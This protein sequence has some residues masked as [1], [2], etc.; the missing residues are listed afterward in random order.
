MLRKAGLRVAVV[1][2]VVCCACAADGRQGGVAPARYAIVDSVILA[3]KGVRLEGDEQTLAD[4]RAFAEGHGLKLFDTA[5]VSGV[6]FVLEGKVDVT[7]AFVRAVQSRR[8][9]GRLELPALDVPLTT[10]AFVT[11]DDFADPNS[12]IKPLVEALRTLE[13]EF[14]PRREEID[15]LLR[16]AE[17]APAERR[18]QLRRDAEL[19][20]QAG[21]AA[22]DKRLKELTDPVYRDIARALQKFGHAEGVSLFFDLSRFRPSDKLPP[23]GLSLP[24]AA[25]NVTRKFVAEYNG[26]RLKP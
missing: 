21:Q 11:S 20:Q 2:A 23:L 4:L 9:G 10:V 18:E 1:V 14:R 6:V 24:T 15:Q 7:D 5:R 25:P 16:Q 12:G 26:G 22:L 17:T 13:K 3:G 8:A 19:R